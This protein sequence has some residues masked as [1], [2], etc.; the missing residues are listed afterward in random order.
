MTVLA[1]L[2]VLGIFVVL[3][4]IIGLIIISLVMMVERSRNKIPGKIRETVDNLV[5]S[6]D[7]DCPTGYVCMDGKCV[8]QNELNQPLYPAT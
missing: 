6:I 1:I 3:P 5:C 7:T 2:E 4:I 8:P